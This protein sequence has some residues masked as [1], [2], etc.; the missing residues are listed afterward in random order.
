L[1]R[2]FDDDAV[3]IYVQD[4]PLKPVLVAG[5]RIDEHKALLMPVRTN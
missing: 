2:T 4:S 1:L 3:S 5:Q